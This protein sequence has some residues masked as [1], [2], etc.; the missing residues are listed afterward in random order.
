MET[1]VARF[2]RDRPQYKSILSCDPSA[3]LLVAESHK[4]VARD[5]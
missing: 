4:D 1:F 2:K 3:V 5:D